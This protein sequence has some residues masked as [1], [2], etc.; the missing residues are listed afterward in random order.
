MRLRDFSLLFCFTRRAA[1]PC[2]HSVLH[3]RSHPHVFATCS[4]GWGGRNPPGR[5][6]RR[7]P[8]PTGPSV[9]AGVPRARP[10]RF[11]GPSA[12][13]R[14]GAGSRL[15]G[16][17]WAERA[18]R[19][20]PPPRPAPAPPHSPHSPPRHRLHPRLRRDRSRGA[21]PGPPVPPP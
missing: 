14:A 10:G 18:P 4:R 6:H 20:A 5:H 8:S 3:L 17:C 11:A 12:A 7:P 19:A 13:A 2:S 1:L 16:R 21:G 15:P 9:T